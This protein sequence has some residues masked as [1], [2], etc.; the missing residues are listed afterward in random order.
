MSPA[1]VRTETAV[2]GRRSP[3]AQGTTPSRQPGR[4]SADSRCGGPITDAA[5]RVR[6]WADARLRRCAR[7]QLRACPVARLPGRASAPMCAHAP[8]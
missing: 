8:A 5:V 2:A 7:A 1:C 6:R 4:R 3:H